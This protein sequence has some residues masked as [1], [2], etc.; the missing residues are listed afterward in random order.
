M[1]NPSVNGSRDIES[2]ASSGSN[3]ARNRSPNSFMRHSWHAGTTQ[4]EL[5]H[6]GG[7]V[8]GRRVRQSVLI[9]VSS[10]APTDTAPADRR[11]HDEALLCRRKRHRTRLTS[12]RSTARP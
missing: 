4:T 11:E 1:C 6:R 7:Q 5:K 12:A 3:T 2:R 10:G 9:G 8:E